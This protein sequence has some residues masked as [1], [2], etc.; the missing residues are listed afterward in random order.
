MN[1]SHI[2]DIAQQDT[3]IETVAVESRYLKRIDYP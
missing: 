3:S 1:S 2:K